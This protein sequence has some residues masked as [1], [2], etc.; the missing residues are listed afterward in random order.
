MEESE[1]ETI[2]RAITTIRKSRVNFII[3]EIEK[4]RQD[5]TGGAKNI[6][7]LRD[8]ENELS[9]IHRNEKSKNFHKRLSEDDKEK[10]KT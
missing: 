5:V 3:K 7:L 2:D 1:L 6:K 10:S 4:I 8:Y 9:E